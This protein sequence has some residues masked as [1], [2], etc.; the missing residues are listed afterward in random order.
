MAILFVK[1]NK[2][3]LEENEYELS[4]LFT[5]ELYLF[6]NENINEYN[7]KLTIINEV[8]LNHIQQFQAVNLFLKENRIELIKLKN[9]ERFLLS[10]IIDAA[11]YSE[12][13]II[14][15][16]KKFKFKKK[17]ASHI[18]ILESMLFLLWQI[19]I[20][21]KSDSIVIQSK[22]IS[23]IRTAAAKKKLAN[24]QDIDIKYENFDDKKTLYNC[25][26]RS[27]RLQWV[28]K[29]WMNSYHELKKYKSMVEK[30]VGTNSALDS[31]H[32]Y[33]KRI[34]HSLLY[35]YMLENYFSENEGKTFYTGNNLDRFAL[36]EEQLSKKYNI[37]IVCIPHG[38]EYGFKLPH[39]F[40]GDV[41]Y[42]TSEEAARHLNF[43]YDTDKFISDLD[44]SKK[45][46]KVD[47]NSNKERRIVFFTEPREVN[48]NLKIIN[49]I[50]PL[51]EK[52]KMKLSIKLH[53]KD[54]RRDYAEYEKQAYFIEEF[55]EAV[56]QNICFARKSTALLE[57]VYNDSK[58]G[59][60]LINQKDKAIFNTFPSLKDKKIKVFYSI[61]DLFEWLKIEWNN[62]KVEWKRTG[63]K[64]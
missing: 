53:P 18:N 59:A 15:I 32:S 37:K 19:I 11:R 12:V 39:C 31:Y 44:I 33:S 26:S 50:L 28:V 56:T 46:F 48:V 1:G 34:I 14:D 61:L 2:L 45:M 42:A 47:G 29:A 6:G 20:R 38:I 63:T 40:V 35:E 17:L 30:F 3:I 64:F 25:F 52:N 13:R 55:T 57:A 7:S 4:D 21:P 5:D 60:I 27:E 23:I 54:H 41:F 62:D 43:I 10:I 9:P 16:P 51:M 49:E 8:Y 36:I 24:M 22:K 58:A